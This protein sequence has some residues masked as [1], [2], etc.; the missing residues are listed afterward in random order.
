MGSLDI[1]IGIIL[2]LGIGF[3]IF[4]I[5]RLS[6][7]FKKWS[8]KNKVSWFEWI[9]IF[10][11]S[12]PALFNIMGEGNTFANIVMLII[13]FLVASTLIKLIMWSEVLLKGYIFPEIKNKALIIAGNILRIVIISLIGLWYSVWSSV[14]I[15]FVYCLAIW[16][17]CNVIFLYFKRKEIKKYIGI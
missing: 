11:L 4:R 15:N 13:A 9:I 14:N 7:S 1:I 16:L 3:L 6:M 17:F 12:L 10:L 5:F 8:K 2:I